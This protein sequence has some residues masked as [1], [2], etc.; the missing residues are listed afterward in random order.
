MAIGAIINSCFANYYK[1]YVGLTD[2]AC[3]DN[4]GIHS[5]I[6]FRAPWLDFY[7]NIFVIMVDMIF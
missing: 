4:A 3:L 6:M 2:T 5:E 1:Q 7:I